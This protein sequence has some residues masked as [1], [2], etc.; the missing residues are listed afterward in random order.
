MNWNKTRVIVTGAGGFI[1]SH[2]CSQLLKLG[3]K[4]T[5]MLHYSSRGD[6]A[7]LEFLP[8]QE[9]SELRVVKG[10]IEDSAFVDAN[11]KNHDIVFHLAAL[12]G[13][14]YSYVAPIS[15][16]KTN[17]EGTANILEAVR[18]FDLQKIIHTSTSE[19]Y[20]TA[21]Y[22]PIDEKHPLQAQS[23]YSATK[24]SA[25]KI[26]E[27]YHR[28]F[29]I[30]VTTVRPFNTYGPRQSGRAVIPTIISQAI[31]EEYIMLG[32][33]SPIR[34]LNYVED[35]ANGFIAAAESDLA[36]GEVIN[37]GSGKGITIG[38]LAAL[39]KE[40]MN[41]DKSIVGDRQRIRPKSSEVFELVCDVSL[42]NKL[43]KWSPKYTLREGLRLTIDFL[44]KH[45][46]FF[47]SNQ[48]GY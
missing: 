30:P 2:L 42:S 9:K 14:P 37:L 6:W 41:C 26:A 29:D 19:V 16:I 8:D 33:L 3:A 45:P 17:I 27:S 35:T 48:Y 40:I 47:K 18:K 5:A 4:V 32:D 23:P 11:V 21:K 36:E 44:Q 43:T 10:N 15:Y 12:I 34:D 31:K 25:D 13:I 38:E 7:N 1:G 22:T 20:G 24:I 39:I 28:A 46:G